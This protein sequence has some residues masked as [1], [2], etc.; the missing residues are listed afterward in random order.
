VEE[1]WLAY[2]RRDAIHAC[3][4]LARGAEHLHRLGEGL[5][6]AW[7]KGGSRAD[8]L[9]LVRLLQYVA[10]VARRIAEGARHGEG[11]RPAFETLIDPMY[12]PYDQAGWRTQFQPPQS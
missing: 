12:V 1:A 4:A 9:R 6:Q 7:E 8:P 10:E 3:E 2:K 11:F 5:I